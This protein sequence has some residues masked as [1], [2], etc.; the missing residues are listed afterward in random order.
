MHMEIGY[1]L[2]SEEHGPLE[3]VRNARRA[4]EAGFS[5]AMISDHFHPWTDRQGSSPFVWSTLGGIAE[6]TRTLRVGT[7]VTCPSIRIHPAIIAQAAATTAVMFEGRFF[8]GLGSGEN[9][10]EHITGRRWPPADERLEMLEEAVDVIRSL[11]T[12]E[13]RT[14]RGRHYTVENAKIYNL[15]QRPPEIYLAAAGKKAAA[16]AGRIAEGLVIVSPQRHVLDSFV[17]SGGRQ[18]P[19]IGQVKV[20]YAPSEDDAVRTVMEWWPTIV[21]PG[22]LNSELPLPSLFEQAAKSAT[23][24]QVRGQVVCGPDPE[25]YLAAI[26]KYFDLGVER[27]YVHQVG[28]EQE[29]FIGFYQREIMPT[30]STWSERETPT[31][32]GSRLR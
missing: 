16:L 26:R 7:A 9:L 12:G 10:N 20:C 25:R 30:V 31:A 1:A 24:E 27:V 3:L 21:V 11:W 13:M 22:A 23:A 17:E 18:R 4:E 6:A 8:L 15:P 14:H 32:T 19:V 29:G 2:S 5:F 28:P